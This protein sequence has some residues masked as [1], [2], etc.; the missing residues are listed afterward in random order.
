MAQALL[1]N[2]RKEEEGRPG[3]TTPGKEGT[4]A[5]GVTTTGSGAAAAA[6]EPAGPVSSPGAAVAAAGATDAEGDAATWEEG[7]ASGRATYAGAFPPPSSLTHMLRCESRP[8]PGGRSGRERALTHCLLGMNLNLGTV[9]LASMTAMHHQLCII[10][11][12]ND[13]TI[14]RG[15]VNRETGQPLSDLE[16][17]AQANVFMLA[18]YETTSL[19]L[20]YTLYALASRPDLQA[21]LAAEAAAAGPAGGAGG[22][23]PAALSYED[24][25]RLPLTEAVF[26]ESMRL[27][28][29]I[30]SLVALVSRGRGWAH[31]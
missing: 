20:S 24:L 3:G 29:P 30:S 14:R 13:S 17:A 12:R 11:T 16:I 23:S 4:P 28:P 10:T 1:D 9:R 26:L 7:F 8:G 25:E 27:Y 5:G 2:A 15:V 21:Q 18:G 31:V 22:G 6:R 19:A